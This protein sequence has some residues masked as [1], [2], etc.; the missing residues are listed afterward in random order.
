MSKLVGS[1]GPFMVF[2][3]GRSCPAVGLSQLRILP[4]C[5]HEL[6]AVTSYV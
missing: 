4:G 6:P 3:F 5:Y 2:N 1:D